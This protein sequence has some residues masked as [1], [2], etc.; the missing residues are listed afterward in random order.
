MSLLLGSGRFWD[1]NMANPSYMGRA[2]MVSNMDSLQS[3]PLGWDNQITPFLNPATAFLLE[4][5]AVDGK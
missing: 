1:V 2:E 3:E 5:D 4:A